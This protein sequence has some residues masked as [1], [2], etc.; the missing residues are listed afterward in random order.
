MPHGQIAGVEPP[1]LESGVGGVLVVEVTG[2]DIVASHDH[3][4]HTL[5][6]LGNVVHVLVNDSQIRTCED[7]WHTLAR[8]EVCSLLNGK[9]VPAGLHG[10]YCVRPV[11]FRESIGVVNDGAHA[12]DSADD[13]GSRRSACGHDREASQIR[14]SGFGR[15]VHH[16]QNG[17]RA[18]HIRDA[19]LS[20]QS[21]NLGGVNAAQAQ[22]RAA[23]R[24]D[25]P[26][27]APAVAM[28]HG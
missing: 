4:A 20:D 9:F 5:A 8:L 16:G 24:G 2:H 12:F 21:V 26:R 22:V 27:V 7:E 11:G 6:V 17:W 18:A 10:A 3:L 1:A 15:R 19:F 14:F 23:H 28:E 25:S 13:L